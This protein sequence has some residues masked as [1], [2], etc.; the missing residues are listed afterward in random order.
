M[1][2]RIGRRGVLWLLAGLPAA[3]ASPNPTLYTLA[4]VP[5][6]THPVAPQRIELREIALA[7]YLER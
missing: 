4:I 7:R 2:T 6:A 1:R 5:G 3:C